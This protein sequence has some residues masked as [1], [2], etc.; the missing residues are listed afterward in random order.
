[1]I[2]IKFHQFG[3]VDPEMFRPPNGNAK[4]FATPA[5]QN[6]DHSTT[7]G[8]EVFCIDVVP[9]LSLLEVQTFQPL[10]EDLA[11]WGGRWDGVHA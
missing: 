2:A 11:K 6:S 7:L 8:A 1:M 9:M 4:G 10:A 3:G 5:D